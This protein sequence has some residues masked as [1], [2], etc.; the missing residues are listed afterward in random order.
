MPMKLQ[1]RL[2]G[3]GMPVTDENIKSVIR[4][5]LIR[6]RDYPNLAVKIRRI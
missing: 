4:E 5:Y 3:A 1:Q 2:S 6:Q